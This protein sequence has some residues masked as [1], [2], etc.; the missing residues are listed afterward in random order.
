ALALN[1][2]NPAALI[3]K[4][5]QIRQQLLAQGR[6]VPEPGKEEGGALA[7]QRGEVNAPLS[8]AKGGRLEEPHGELQALQSEIRALAARAIAR[9]PLNAEAYRLLAEMTADAGQERMLMQEAVNRSRRES[10]AVFWLLNDSF[11]RKDY[12]VS[13][14]HAEIL[15]RTRP[16]L[17]DYVLAYVLYIAEDAKGLPLVVEALAKQ[18]GWRR[19]FFAFLPR[20]A[21]GGD[22]PFQLAAALKERGSPV[23]AS[24]LAPFLDALIRDNRADAA[25][26]LWLQYLPETD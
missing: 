1:P 6:P 21:R 22:A 10:V 19:Q 14:G 17:A 13:L 15:L 25:Y 4:A 18:P 7:S 26:N 24:E 12:P 9:D 20:A 8:E 2:S 11:Y 23:S 5:Q 16:E 3:A